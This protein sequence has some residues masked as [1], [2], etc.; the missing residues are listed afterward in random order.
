MEKRVSKNLLRLTTIGLMAALVYLGNYLQIE[1][2]NGILVT[3]IH[4]GNSMC[5]LAGLLFGGMSGGL[6]SGIGAAFFD[7]FNPAYILSSPYTF[8]SK[9]AMGFAAGKLNRKN[10]DGA[11]PIYSTII[12]AVIGQLVYIVLYLIKSYFTVLI[13]GGTPEAAWA[14]VATNSI[15]SVINAGLAVVIS[16]PLYIALRKVLAR[17]EVGRLL[18]G[19]SEKKGYFNPLTA[20]LTVFAIVTTVV[21]SIN[22]AAQPKITAAQEKEKAALQSEISVLEEK[23]DKLYSELGVEMPQTTVPET[24]AG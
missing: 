5:L 11:V 6:S 1:I 24:T 9:F 16:V 17:T 23:I 22:L 8:F 7:L 3:R 12:A 10:A 2:P 4:L 13:I 14:A 18:G 21:F 20:V 19:V 15:V